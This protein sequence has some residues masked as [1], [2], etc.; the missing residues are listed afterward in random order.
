M[1]RNPILELDPDSVAGGARATGLDE[2]SDL[3]LLAWAAEIVAVPRRDVTSFVLHAPLELIARYRLLGGLREA[4]R[5]L[6]RFQL[7]RFA[8]TYAQR[9]GEAVAQP[10]VDS[11]DPSALVD[12]LDRGDPDAAQARAAAL[13]ASASP[14][15]LTSAVGAPMLRR[16]GAAAHGPIFLSLLQKLEPE[17]AKLAAPMLAPLARQLAA[18]NDQRLTWAGPGAADGPPRLDA[19]DLEGALLASPLKPF[20][21]GIFPIMRSAEAHGVP[22]SVIGPRV[23]A[24]LSAAEAEPGFAAIC[25][26]AALAMP[27]EGPREAKYGWS[28]CLTLPQAVWE[29]AGG[30]GDPAFALKVAATYVAGMR[31]GIGRRRRLT[32]RLKVPSRGPVLA[33]ALQRSPQAAAEAAWRA[34]APET[35]TVFAALVAEAAIRPDAHLIKYVT[36]CRDGAR[37]DPA[38]APAYRAGAA[39]LTALWMAEQPLADVARAL[40]AVEGGMAVV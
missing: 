31:A 12:A 10:A 40:G 26:V 4:A 3:Q 33:E 7:L 9:T 17:A 5:P 15:E 25:R 24:T 39:Y 23:P 36:S 16:L 22:Q 11:A 13:A 14:V 21:G 6:A 19:A 1:T 35:E 27:Q 2:A 38:S 34:E 28:H 29:I 20:A 37:R 32:P 8:A 18:Q 30:V